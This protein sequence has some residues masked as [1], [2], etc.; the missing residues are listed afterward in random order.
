MGEKTQ[1]IIEIQKQIKVL[2]QENRRDY[3]ILG[4][5]LF[6]K[7]GKNDNQKFTAVFG[8][9]IRIDGEIKKAEK[10]IAEIETL[11]SREKT[12]SEEIHKLENQMRYLEKDNIKHF[13][14]IG[15]TAYTAYKASLL[16]GEEF[17]EVFRQLSGVADKI[18]HF[19][20]RIKSVSGK[21]QGILQKIGGGVSRIVFTTRKSIARGSAER[22]FQK[23][24][25]EL[26]EKNIIDSVATK[27]VA[28]AARPYYDNAEALESMKT[29]FD[30]LG[31]DRQRVADE[32]SRKCGTMRP[33]MKIEALKDRIAA[34]A[35]SADQQYI[36]LGEKA[37]GV[38][39]ENLAFSA[40]VETLFS[41]IPERVKTIKKLKAEQ[42]RLNIEIRIEQLN[43]DRE[44]ELFSLSVQKDKIRDA[45]ERIKTSEDHIASLDAEI[46]KLSA[47][48]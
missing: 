24:G 21:K 9:L 19:E 30:D 48:K 4:S 41:E 20:D 10:T 42:S 28:L 34:L 39:A 6:E 11:Q 13:E 40:G 7:N 47:K 36:L 14:K 44:K 43:E 31:K 22:L 33:P 3:R 46:K 32:I 1:R 37:V 29:A 15:S 12:I 26:V 23:A 45:E 8:E 27:E 38:K 18:E 2:D 25:R 35:Q 5:D 17:D 16:R